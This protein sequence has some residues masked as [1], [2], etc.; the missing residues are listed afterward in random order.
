M[1]LAAYD[2]MKAWGRTN[3]KIGGC[4][5]MPRALQAVIDGRMVAT[6]RNPSC[7]IHGGAIIA[8]VAGYPAKRPGWHGNDPEA[9]GDGRTVITKANAPGL[10]WM[11][12]H[13]LI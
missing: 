1:A 4:D 8:G 3:I 6:V 11:E 2:V 7:L 9:H 5:A 13:F 10:I 12:E